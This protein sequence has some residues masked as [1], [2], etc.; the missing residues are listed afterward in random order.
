MIKRNRSTITNR[1][2][3]CGCIRRLRPGNQT[4]TGCVVD[5]RPALMVHV[6][7]LGRVRYPEHADVSVRAIIEKLVQCQLGFFG[8]GPEALVPL[9]VEGLGALMHVSGSTISRQLRRVT[10]LGPRGPEE[11][12]N[13]FARRVGNTTDVMIRSFLVRVFTA[14]PTFT[15]LQAAEHLHERHGV[16]VARRT[17]AKYRRQLGFGPL[18]RGL[19]TKKPRPRLPHILVMKPK[20]T[21]RRFKKTKAL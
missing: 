17:V 18:G 11:A 4:C 19:F 15:D 13:L 14:W 6:D 12:H 8:T 5:G 7:S 9:T 2:K 20:S 10:L 16:I 21:E 3:V 1:C